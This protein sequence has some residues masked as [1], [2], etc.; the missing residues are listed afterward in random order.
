MLYLQRISRRTNRPKRFEYNNKIEVSTS[1]NLSNNNSNFY[2]N[3]NKNAHGN[4]CL[5]IF[6][7]HYIFQLGV[8]YL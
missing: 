1:N 3:V 2:D 4:F 6:D 8:V 7:E 5:W